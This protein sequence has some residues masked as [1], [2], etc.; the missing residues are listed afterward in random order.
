MSTVF[1]LHFTFVGRRWQ[2]LMHH[3]WCHFSYCETLLPVHQA[4]LVSAW[5]SSAWD[6]YIWLPCK[7]CSPYM[8]K[9]NIK[10]RLGLNAFPQSLCCDSLSALGCDTLL[11]RC[12]VSLIL[13]NYF[14]PPPKDSKHMH[15]H[16][17][18]HS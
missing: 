8:C 4:N 13:I 10:S 9:M 14:S 7:L 6:W 2:F 18:R 11:S 15:T 17:Y 1:F 16:L 5:F 12:S 3:K